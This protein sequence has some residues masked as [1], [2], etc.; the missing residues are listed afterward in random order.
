M[1]TIIYLTRIP[2]NKTTCKH[3][4]KNN[5]RITKFTWYNFDKSIKMIKKDV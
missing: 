5:N 2:L 3:K 4:Y 1:G